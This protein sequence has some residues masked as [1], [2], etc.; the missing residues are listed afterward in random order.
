[1]YILRPKYNDMSI[2]KLGTTAKKIKESLT[3]HWNDVIE[4][5][6]FYDEKYYNDI[7]IFL[8]FSFKNISDIQDSYNHTFSDTYYVFELI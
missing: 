3:K 8:N 2:V 5:P 1:M 7:N 4:F 6:E